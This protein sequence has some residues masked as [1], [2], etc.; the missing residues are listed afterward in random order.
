MGNFLQCAGSV[1]DIFNLVLYHRLNCV[2]AR[3][4]VFTRVEVRRIFSDVLADFRSHC[5]TKVSVNVDLA[6]AVLGRFADHFLRN[7]LRARNVAAVLIALIDKFLQNR[8]CFF[9]PLTFILDTSC[10]L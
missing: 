5:Q 9:V 3:P 4:E 2:S 6:D 10:I 7:A 8:G 1:Q